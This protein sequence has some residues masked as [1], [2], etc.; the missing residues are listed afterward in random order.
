MKLL[1]VEDEKALAQGL[2]FNF[3]QEGYSVLTAEDG[4]TALNYFRECY[5]TEKDNIDLVI[6]DLMLPGMSG[7][8][9][10]KEIR[11]IDEVVPI[12]VLS[13]RELSEDK[14]YAF[15]CGTD[16]YMTKPFALP[17]LLSRV[18]NLLKRKSVVRPVPVE[19]RKLPALY[20]FG[21]VTVDFEAFE[22]E[23][24]G[25]RKSLTNL[26]LRLL[27][28]FIE[29]E[30]MVL[31]RTQILDDVWGEQ[32]AFVTTRTIDNFV[33]RLRKLVESNPAEPV[34]IVSV[35]GAGYRFM[36]EEASE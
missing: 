1:V 35:R 34:H 3:E 6:L 18:K 7:Y 26:E 11:R 2:K 8:E 20:H 13:A 16:Q 27:K 33:L 4:P 31:T 23:V 14:A 29:H 24:D 9:I 19:T 22:V 10:A 25:E 15:D 12:L 36:P 5:E 28:Y 21:N 30:G 32:S 17:E